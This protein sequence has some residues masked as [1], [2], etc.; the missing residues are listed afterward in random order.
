M[1]PNNKIIQA[2]IH[3]SLESE[4][5]KIKMSNTRKFIAFSI[6]KIFYGADS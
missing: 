2:C 6:V 1:I 5:G 3:A 4:Q